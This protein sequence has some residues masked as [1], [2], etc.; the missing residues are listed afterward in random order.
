MPFS[1]IPGEQVRKEFRFEF[2]GGGPLFTPSTTIWLTN[3]RLVATESFT[4]AS[5]ITK[6]MPLEHI[7]YMQSGRFSSPR[8]LYASIVLLLLG[9]VGMLSI[10]G[11][12]VGI[13]S[14]LVGLVCFLVYLFKRQN[15]LLVESGGSNTL[16]LM[17]R[18][19]ASQMEEVVR[20][21]E[22]ARLARISHEIAPVAGS[23][24]PLPQASGQVSSPMVG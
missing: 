7:I 21:V 17:L 18:G 24:A 4:R 1:P 13:I 11:I 12:I 22:L 16:T 20:E 5:E 8:W 6:Y 9:I 15:T 2:K 14:I 23:S 19:N 3:L 10:V